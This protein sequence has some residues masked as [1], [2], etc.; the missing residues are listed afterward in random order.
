MKARPPFSN[1]VNQFSWASSAISGIDIRV[2]C[3][4]FSIDSIMN[5]IMQKKNARSGRRKYWLVIDE[6]VKIFNN[7]GFIIQIKYLTWLSN[8][9]LVY[10]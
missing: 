4:H 1:G 6:E 3:H 5:P 10:K 8:V 9:L 2:V 7:A